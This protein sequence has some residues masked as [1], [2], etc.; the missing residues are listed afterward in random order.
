M[1][2]SHTHNTLP[3]LPAN[4]LRACRRCM[5]CSNT[6]RC[7]SSTIPTAFITLVGL[8]CLTMIS[9]SNPHSS[10]RCQYWPSPS[11]DSHC[12]TCKLLSVSGGR[13][14]ASTGSSMD[15]T[16][17]AGIPAMTRVSASHTCYTRMRRRRWI[18]TGWEESWSETMVWV[19]Q[20]K[21]ELGWHIPRHLA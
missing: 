12:S 11:D 16:S 20:H 18:L 14:S 13:G 2:Q 3:P 15:A 8:A 21:G 6:R 19:L 10:N 7:S 4:Y 9:L 1:N 17:R 5:A